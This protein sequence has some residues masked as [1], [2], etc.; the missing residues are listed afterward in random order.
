MDCIKKKVNEELKA[1]WIGPNLQCD[2]HPSHFTGQDCTFCYCPF[3][4]CEDTDLGDFIVGRR[5]AAG[6][7]E[8]GARGSGTAPTA[9]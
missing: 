3:Y 7:S 2:Y 4:P 5:G 9:S 6:S 1:G 8:G